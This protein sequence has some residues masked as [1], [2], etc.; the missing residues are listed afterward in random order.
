[1]TLKSKYCQLYCTDNETELQTWPPK[2]I[3]IEIIITTVQII[4]SIAITLDYTVA[5]ITEL[6]YISSN[7]IIELRMCS[8]LRSFLK[9]GIATFQID[10]IKISLTSP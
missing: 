5:K 6:Y 3:T 10:H 4:N 7:T 1:M 8:L 9:C 2:I